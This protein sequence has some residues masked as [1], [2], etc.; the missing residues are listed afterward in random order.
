MQQKDFLVRTRKIVTW[1]VVVQ[2]VLLVLMFAGAPERVPAYL[3]FVAG[4]QGS[5]LAWFLAGLTAIGYAWSAASIS[6]VRAY[7]FKFDGLKTLALVAAVGAGVIEEVF[8]RKLL[9]D[10]LQAQGYGPVIQVGTSAIAFGIA[11]V[12]WGVK[13]RAAAV[14]AALSTTLLGAAL[15]V[16]YLVG[17]RS[18]A[19][20][21]VA[22]VAI[23]VL[24]EP[25]LILAAVQGRLGYWRERK[26]KQGHAS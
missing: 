24:I 23:D 12:V 26:R 15:A 22:H 5:A 21:V 11:H 13:S 2:A 17:D 14:N 25:G 18:L 1:I 19:P 16:V 9:M 20:C 10:Y 8:F 3:G 6:T 4:A 7:M